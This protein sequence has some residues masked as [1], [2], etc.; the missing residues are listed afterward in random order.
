MLP[1]SSTNY[2]YLVEMGGLRIA[3]FG[4]IGQKILTQ[5]QLGSLGQVD[6]AIT[7]FSNPYS[8]MSAE[9][10]KGL[11][12]MDQVKP[13]LVIPTHINLD[14][15]KLTLERYVGYYTDKPSVRICKSMLGDQASILYMGEW[16]VEF[17]GTLNL[18]EVDW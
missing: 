1:E 3:H 14:A 4:D 6:I 18:F 10:Q 7:Q 2:I 5:E 12:L 9:N 11:Q 13:Q 15:A 16:A 8:D 17:A